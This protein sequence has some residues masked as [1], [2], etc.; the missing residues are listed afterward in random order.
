MRLTPFTLTQNISVDN[1]LSTIQVM[2]QIITKVNNVVDYVNNLEI[3]AN[4]YTD[5]QIKLVKEELNVV[6]NELETSITNLGN[7]L[8][9]EI[10]INSEHISDLNNKLLVINSELDEI[11]DRIDSTFSLIESNYNS[12]ILLI[13]KLKEYVDEVIEEMTVK[14]Y[15]PVTGKKMNIQ[16]CLVELMN[17]YQIDFGN[18][19]LSYLK[20]LFNQSVQL[21]EISF[22]IRDIKFS[23]LK[24]LPTNISYFHLHNLIND[25]MYSYTVKHTFK[26]SHKYSFYQIIN[27]LGMAI[28]NSNSNLDIMSVYKALSMML[29]SSF[30]WSYSSNILKNISW[31]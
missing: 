25:T 9:G 17:L 6:K 19:N 27:I 20:K 2:H 18:I 26:E 10:Q 3:D 13:N 30:G 11:N 23:N 8:S 22:N 24:N 1:A 29:Y 14:V 31:I 7:T 21:N 5:E 15:S 28:I 4:T 16:K 12:I